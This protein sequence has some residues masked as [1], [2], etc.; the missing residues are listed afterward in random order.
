MLSGKKSGQP[1]LA[2]DGKAALRLLAPSAH[3]SSARLP[4]E[5]E[6]HLTRGLSW[7]E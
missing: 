5:L 3:N 2:A 1:N 4:I 7:F 6:L